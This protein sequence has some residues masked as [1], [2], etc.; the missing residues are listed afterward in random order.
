MAGEEWQDYDYEKR[1]V[2]LVI[3]DTYILILFQFLPNANL[4]QSNLDIIS[5]F[6]RDMDVLQDAT[7]LLH[8]L[9][10]TLT[11]KSTTAPI[12]LCFCVVFRRLVYTMLLVSLDCPIFDFSNVYIAQLQ[13]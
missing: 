7:F 2:F 3:T 6:S 4:I 12:V 13:I 1:N 10:L 8:H 5:S 9:T 11:L